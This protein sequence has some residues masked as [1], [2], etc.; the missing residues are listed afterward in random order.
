MASVDLAT[1]DEDRLAEWLL[2]RRWFGSKARDVAQ[3]HVLDVVTIHE[4]PPRLSAA[5]V[6]ARFP[7]GTHDVYQLMLGTHGDGSDEAVVGEIGGVEVYDAFADPASCEILG[8]L[9][10]EGSEIHGE[11]AR[12]EFHWLASVEPPRPGAAVRSIGA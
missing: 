4:G 6:E 3:I 9:L 1:L 8:T 10:R 2:G 7:G 11:H 12:V 5:L